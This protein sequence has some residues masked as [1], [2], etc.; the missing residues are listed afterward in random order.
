MAAP[1]I[2]A[3]SSPAPRTQSV[4]A[5]RGAIMMLM[6]IDHIR[7]YVARGAGTAFRGE[8]EGPRNLRPAK[9][10]CHFTEIA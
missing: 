6:A 9:G 8:G 5:I 7:D 10:H 2:S 1:A 4:D 3:Q